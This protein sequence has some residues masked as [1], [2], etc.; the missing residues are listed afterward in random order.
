L[1]LSKGRIGEDAS[2]LLGAMMITKLQLAAM[3]R[4]DIAEDSRKDF[5]LYVDEFQNFATESFANILSEA[6]KYR[7]NLTVA[8]QYIEQ[9]SDE[10]RAAVFGNVGTLI[11]FRVG[12]ADAEFL[13]KE[14]S[15]R[16]DEEDLVNL[17]KYNIYLKLM[18][19]GIASD[20]FSASSLPPISKIT[21]SEEMVVKVCRERYSKS[22][23]TVEDK[24][25][26]WSGV[27]TEAMI[28]RLEKELE[29]KRDDGAQP[30]KK[31]NLLKEKKDIETR[32]Q[33]EKTQEKEEVVQI[34]KCASCGQKTKI[35]FI[36]DPSRPVF[37]KECLKE[38]RRKQALEEN[39][40]KAKDLKNKNQGRGELSLK[41]LEKTKP[42]SFT[43]SN[44]N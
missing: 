26:R 9:L 41:D 7:L 37:C 30:E 14:F 32:N 2:S 15:P 22:R 17:P 33:P 12:A 35:N 16:F 29:K 23:E 44:K 3:S 19:D 24:I 38:Y 36:P 25:A 39:A 5:Y 11:C 27:E 8:H 21:D 18:I 10:V 31:I 13:V 34:I 43:D 1:N 20:P 6:R 4:V 40:R 28:E 42:S